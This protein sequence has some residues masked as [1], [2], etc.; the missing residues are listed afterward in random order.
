[1]NHFDDL[2][3]RGRNHVIEEKA[4][5]AFK[6]RLS[7]SGLFILQAAD[8]KDYGTDCQI[9][10][11]HLN[12]ATNVRVHVQLKGTERDLNADGSISV[13]ISRTNLNYLLVHPHSFYA[14]YHVPTD[15]LRICFADS[16]LRQYDHGGPGWTEQQTLTVSLSEALTVER[17]STLAALA[18]SGARLSRDRRLGQTTA[19]A[20]DVPGILRRSLPDIEVPQDR[21]AAAKILSHLYESG[22]DA[23]ISTGFG[24]FAAVFGAD[25]DAM[26]SCYMAEINLGMARRS[27]FPERIEGAV[28][29]FRAKLEGGRFQVGSAH[30]TIGNAF[31]ALGDEQHAK[32]AY[33]A[34][35]ADPDVFSA[36][37]LAAQ[38]LKNLGT[39]LARLGDQDGAAQRYQEALRLS[40]DLP[41]AHNALG[42][43]YYRLGR[44]ENALTHFDRVVFTE[45]QLGKT[46]AVAGWRANILFNLGDGRGA[47][48]D[49]NTLLSQADTEE[50]IW[51]WCARLVNNFGRTTAGNA[52]QALAFWQRYISVHPNDSV[53]RRELLLATFYLRRQGHDVGASYAEFRDVFDLHIA[54]VDADDAAL[55]WDRLGHWA[56]EEDN[57]PEAER[58]FRKAYEIEGGHYGYCLGTALNFLGRC[59]ESLPILREQA[60]VIQP[61]AMSWYQV[62]VACEGTNQV[63]SAIE[64]YGKVI[65]LDPNLSSAIFN[66]GGV[67]WNSGDRIEAEKVWRLAVERFP[68]HEL[69]AKLRREMPFVFEG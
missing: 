46:S 42:N 6:T 58:C 28:A 9:E 17:L 30:Y 4:E 22:A 10:V 29:Y 36:P 60:E 55:P 43:H 66:L 21:A 69:T 40:P 3:Q 18:Q 67:H 52:T 47:F 27:R 20:A 56:Q 5:A 7:E 26:G 15:S 57:W 32:E 65:A 25:D 2:P 54:H 23:V 44:Y 11:V 8:R 34:A 49:I 61:D 33:E 31:S 41:E 24:K 39:S 63:A 53:A 14:C 35:L 19:D 59:E 37:A 62:A 45:R 13:E 48:R 50:W 12:Q 51:P 1:M 68:D 16:V 64:A 38:V